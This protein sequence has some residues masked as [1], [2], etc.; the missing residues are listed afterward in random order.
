M[1]IQHS[2]SED[3]SSIV[4]VVTTK[5]IKQSIRLWSLSDLHGRPN[6]SEG[7]WLIP[8]VIQ[9]EVKV[10]LDVWLSWAGVIGYVG[11]L[12][13]P[14]DEGSVPIT[15][16]SWTGFDPVHLM[17]HQMRPESLEFGCRVRALWDV[18]YYWSYSK[19]TSELVPF[20]NSINQIP[21]VRM[22]S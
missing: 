7:F 18:L 4:T 15:R 2:L 13:A 3:R 12:R 19:S 10:S 8:S 11:A 16:Q 22:S 1:T 14:Y 17:W 21:G 6:P 5:G 20:G 9:L